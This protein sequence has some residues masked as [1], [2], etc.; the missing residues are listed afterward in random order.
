MLLT[1]AASFRYACCLVVSDIQGNCPMSLCMACSMACTILTVRALLSGHV[2]P[3]ELKVFIDKCVRQQRCVAVKRPPAEV[4]LPVV[5]RHRV[6]LLVHSLEEIWIADVEAGELG[7]AVIGE[8]LG[9]F[10]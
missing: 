3:V 8:I 1:I 6:E 7:R 5:E 2:P 10:E 9:E 4:G